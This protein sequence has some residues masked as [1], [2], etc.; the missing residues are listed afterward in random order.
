MFFTD[1]FTSDDPAA[2]AQVKET[3]LK[4][5]HEKVTILENHMKGRQWLVGDSKTFADAHLYVF[6]RWI[7]IYMTPMMEDF[8]SLKTWQ[9]M[10][11]SRMK[12]SGVL[13]SQAETIDLYIALGARDVLDELGLTTSEL[14]EVSNS[15]Y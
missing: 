13:T 11:V 15:V 10:R 3:G 1:R 5:V 9:R 2:L 8:P 4:R 6:I 7:T 14:E 12:R